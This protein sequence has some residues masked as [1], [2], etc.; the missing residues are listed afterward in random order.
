MY[1]SC[2]LIHDSASLASKKYCCAFSDCNSLLR[3]FSTAS[4][5]CCHL[6]NR[7]SISCVN[8]DASS[9]PSSISFCPLLQTKCILGSWLSISV[10]NDWFFFLSMC[11]LNRLL[12][13]SV[14]VACGIFSAIHS[15]SSSMSR[16]NWNASFFFSSCLCLSSRGAFNCSNLISTWVFFTWISSIFSG[17]VRCKYSA[18][19]SSSDTCFA[20][21]AICVSIICC[22]CMRILTEA[23]SVPVSSDSICFSRSFIHVSM[24]SHVWWSKTSRFASK[25]LSPFSLVVRSRSSNCWE[26]SDILGSISSASSGFSFTSSSAACWIWKS[27]SLLDAISASKAWCRVHLL[28]TVFALRYV[29]SWAVIFFSCTHSLSSSQSCRN[30]CSCNWSFSFSICWSARS[31][32]ALRLSLIFSAFLWTLSAAKWPSSHRRLANCTT[33]LILSSLA[34]MVVRKAS[35]RFIKFSACS[36]LIGVSSL[37]ST[38]SCCDNKTSACLASRLNICRFSDCDSSCC[39]FSHI[40]CSSSQPSFKAFKRSRRNIYWGSSCVEGSAVMRSPYSIIFV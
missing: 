15:F 23:R 7:S 2:S 27:L 16:R 14:E 3:R 25:S 9:C 34:S 20:F 12:P 13:Y 19:V 29:S 17:A 5:S 36:K 21:T 31:R 40:W 39:L 22:F 6:A 33:L 26:S 32:L 10:R 1:N 11:T 30:W 8:S 24:S 4:F 35:C 18:C 37:L 38:C 28:C